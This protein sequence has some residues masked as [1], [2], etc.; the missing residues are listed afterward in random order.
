MKLSTS[1]IIKHSDN[2]LIEYIINNNEI[3]FFSDISEI[4]FPIK[5][6]K[7]VS[8]SENINYSFQ[9]VDYYLLENKTIARFTNHYTNNSS[10]RKLL[11]TFSI[12]D[13]KRVFKR[14]RALSEFLKL[15]KQ[16]LKK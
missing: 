16:L 14:R 1:D 9:E 8:T 13:Y 4:Y 11:D 3:G 15:E 5:G 10:Y 7:F 2:I 6:I 12:P